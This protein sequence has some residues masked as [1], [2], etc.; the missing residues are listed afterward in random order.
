MPG[1]AAPI[2]CDERGVAERGGLTTPSPCPCAV[3]PA[4]LLFFAF[5]FTVFA[6]SRLL[7][8]VHMWWEDNPDI[9]TCIEYC[10]AIS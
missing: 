2:V 4:L 10:L 5:T 7:C 6:L 1:D 3:R 9:Y 8:I